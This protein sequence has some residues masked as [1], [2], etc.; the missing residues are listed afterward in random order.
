MGGQSKR[1]GLRLS[2]SA[3]RI[4]RRSNPTG[5]FMERA[6]KGNTRALCL[7][8]GKLADPYCTLVYALRVKF[9]QTGRS[10]TMLNVNFSTPE[11]S[12]Q[13]NAHD[14]ILANLIKVVFRRFS[15]NDIS[16]FGCGDVYT[17]PKDL[18]KNIQKTL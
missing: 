8:R 10:E 11:H 4:M 1:R 12:N 2:S 18:C 6:F 17:F 15:P 13:F 5:P 3:S 16:S 7:L 9:N 14:Q